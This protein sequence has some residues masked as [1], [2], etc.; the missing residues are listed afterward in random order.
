MEM[1][2]FRDMAMQTD[3]QSH[4][5][6]VDTQPTFVDRRSGNAISVVTGTTKACPP[7]GNSQRQ[8]WL[9]SNETT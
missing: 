5:E 1:L 2:P 8:T 4:G 6:R 3:K 7:H 9:F